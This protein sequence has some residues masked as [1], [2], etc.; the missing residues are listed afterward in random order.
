MDAK[1]STPAAAAECERN[2]RKFLKFLA[3]SPCFALLAN[4]R[5]ASADTGPVPIPNQYGSGMISTPKDAL[6]VTDFSEPCR[7]NSLPAH[8]GYLSS[9]TDGDAT[10][11][12][13]RK[14]FDHYQLR[15]R[16]LLGTVAG[17]VSTATELWGTTYD[18]PLF[19]A[20][21]GGHKTYHPEGEIAVARAAKNRNAMMMLS[22][23]T[24]CSVEDVGQALG[25]APWYQMYAP[26]GWPQTEQM[27]R[28]VEAAG[29]PA[30]AVTVDNISGRNMVTFDRARQADRG[31]CLLCHKSFSRSE[32]YARPMFKGLDMT[33]LVAPNPAL[34][35]AF[36]DRLRKATKLKIAI[37][38]LDTAEDAKLCLEHGVDGIVVSNHGGRA[39]DTGRATIDALGEVLAAVNGR[40]PV[41]VDSGF[42]RGSDVFKALAMGAKAV[43]IGR[44]YI[45]GLG[46]F[47]EAGVDRV[48]EILQMELKVVMAGCGAGSIKDIAPAHI[49]K[50]HA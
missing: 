10:L 48:L 14:G 19:L 38:G 21:I 34:D 45:W 8:W 12:A 33:G 26:S 29:C 17:K 41:F 11:R 40:I 36:I 22:T 23:P 42:R 3:A 50:A 20:P 4:T 9:G 25:R 35:W 31:N 44:P 7:H 27:V 15:P 43:G 28:R 24:T 2:R 49:M 1:L 32:L 37:K 46:S 18:S 16:R 30:I 5:F 47:G 6:E 39:T 13:N